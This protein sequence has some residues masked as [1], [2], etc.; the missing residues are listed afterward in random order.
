MTTPETRPSLLLR[1]RNPQ[2]IDAWDQFVSLYRPVIFR[3]ARMKGMQVADAEDLTQTVFLAV[4]RA[5]ERWN[6]DPARGKFRTWLRTIA[7]NALLNA[8]TRGGRDR[9]AADET[10]DR[11]LEESPDR[12][13]IDSQLLQVEYQRQVFLIAARTI[14]HEFSHETW[15]S[16]WLTAVE[17]M[18]VD[19]AAVKLSRTRGSVYASR[20]RVMKRLKQAIATLQPPEEGNPIE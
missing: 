9:A 14:R 5:I 6:P 19:D 16:F 8:L 17:G 13:G 12:T 4:S 10:I 2:D 11:L 20:S 18:N 3:M 1:V 7:G 15:S